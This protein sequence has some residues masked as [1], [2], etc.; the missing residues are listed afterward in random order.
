MCLHLIKIPEDPALST[1][2]SQF[3]TPNQTNF[4]TS[5]AKY[6]KEFESSFISLSNE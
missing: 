1:G 4:E 3:S 6:Y 2:D 5:V